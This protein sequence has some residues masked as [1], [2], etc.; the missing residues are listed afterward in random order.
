MPHDSTACCHAPLSFGTVVSAP[1]FW[2]APSPR[3]DSGIHSLDPFFDNDLGDSSG[4]E[5]FSPGWDLL[6]QEDRSY[7]FQIYRKH[8]S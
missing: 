6:G 1:L 3:V 4:E 8:F 2:D 7:S 5:V